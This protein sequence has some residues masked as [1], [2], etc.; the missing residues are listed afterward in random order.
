MLAEVCH[1]LAGGPHG[2]HVKLIPDLPPRHLL[3]E[4]VNDFGPGPVSLVLEEI[5]GVIVGARY[6]APEAGA[7]VDWRSG[8]FSSG[9]SRRTRK[10]KWSA[11]PPHRTRSSEMS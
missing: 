10:A 7:R 5:G 11:P 8:T 3:S 2:V 4:E 1:D 6:V 9:R